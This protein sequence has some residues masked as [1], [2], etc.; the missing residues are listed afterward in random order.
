MCHVC[1]PPPQKKEKIPERKLLFRIFIF[2]KS[3]D[4]CIKKFWN[5][6]DFQANFYI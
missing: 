6:F 3:I 4:L 1:T 2:Q 5:R